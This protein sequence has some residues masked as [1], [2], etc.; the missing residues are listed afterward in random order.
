MRYLWLSV[1]AFSATSFLACWKESCGVPMAEDP[2]APCSCVNQNLSSCPDLLNI[3]LRNTNIH[4][5]SPN[6]LGRSTGLQQLDLTNNFLTELPPSLFANSSN[7]NELCLSRNQI[8]QLCSHVFDNLESLTYLN[9]ERN[10]LTELPDGLF[11]KNTNL[12]QLR[13][14]HNQLA[15]LPSCLFDTLESLTFLSLHSN[16]LS[17]D[18]RLCVLESAR[19]IINDTE[20]L[21]IDSDVESYVDIN[22]NTEFCSSSCE[23]IPRKEKPCPP[24]FTCHGDVSNYTCIDARFECA[25]YIL[26]VNRRTQILALDARQE[27]RRQKLLPFRLDYFLDMKTCFR[28][29]IQEIL[30][31]QVK[32]I[33]LKDSSNKSFAR[34]NLETRVVGTPANQKTT[35]ADGYVCGREINECDISTPCSVGFRCENTRGSY[36]CVD[37]RNV[38]KALLC[39]GFNFTINFYPRIDLLAARTHCLNKQNLPIF[40]QD[41]VDNFLKGKKCYQDSRDEFLGVRIQHIWLKLRNTEQPKIGIYNIDSQKIDAGSTADGFICGKDINECML[42]APCLAGYTC[43]NTKSSYI[44]VDNAKI[45]PTQAG[46]T[47]TANQN[48]SAPN[49]TAVFSAVSMV[50]TS[51]PS[52]MLPTLTQQL[53]TLSDV[54]IGATTTAA[55]QGD[56]PAV[57]MT[58]R[59]TNDHVFYTPDTG[60]QV[61]IPVTAVPS[62]A[63]DPSAGGGDATESTANTTTL[64]PTPFQEYLPPVVPPGMNFSAGL[65]IGAGLFALLLIVFQLYKKLGRIRK[66]APSIEDH[67]VVKHIEMQPS[68]DYASVDTVNF[69]RTQTVKENLHYTQTIQVGPLPGLANDQYPQCGFKR[70]AELARTARDHLIMH[71]EFSLTSQDSQMVLTPNDLTDLLCTMPSPHTSPRTERSRR[72][73]SHSSMVSEGSFPLHRAYT[74]STMTSLSTDTRTSTEHMFGSNTPTSHTNSDDYD[75]DCSQSQY[76]YDNDHRPSDSEQ[77]PDYDSANENSRTAT[78]PAAAAFGRSKTFSSRSTCPR[79]L[80]TIEGRVNLG[81]IVNEHIYATGSLDSTNNST[82]NSPTSSGKRENNYDDLSWV[83]PL[84]K[85]PYKQPI[86]SATQLH[87]RICVGGVDSRHRDIGHKRVQSGTLSLSLPEPRCNVRASF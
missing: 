72:T 85:L 40:R 57:D 71:P 33:W 66:S 84:C 1:W 46:G 43:F 54:G 47:Y 16:S 5:L 58:T 60:V 12:L 13:L 3:S 29:A 32:M 80:P 62:S 38:T 26:T 11:Q 82:L 8:R 24:A 15:S 39:N 59:S 65:G 35:T 48:T 42:F 14:S 63:S 34:Y 81:A 31:E 79:D 2:C 23:S 25:G 78:V 74:A 20:S 19:Y 50:A 7:L 56:T 45:D 27:C 22:Q 70:N 75:F 77:D 87:P 55:S 49:N 4:H 41:L 68:K 18:H 36:T 44:C 53:P 73:A 37:Q 61:T 64:T 30:L 28:D 6:L 83:E 67:P 52:T 21:V 86:G 9:L 51:Y 76:L 10:S 17:L 69:H